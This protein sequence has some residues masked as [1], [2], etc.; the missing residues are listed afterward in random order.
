[1]GDVCFLA[2][3][4]DLPRPAIR[5]VGT[6]HF[7]NTTCFVQPLRQQAPHK[8]GTAGHAHLV[9]LCGQRVCPHAMADACRVGLLAVPAMVCVRAKVLKDVQLLLIHPLC[10]P[11][12][13]VGRDQSK[14]VNLAKISL[15]TQGLHKLRVM[16]HDDPQRRN[17]LHLSVIII[18]SCPPLAMRV[19][20]EL[21]DCSIQVSWRLERR[22]P[23]ETPPTLQSA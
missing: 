3:A 15:R 16:P 5:P 23:L 9:C 21:R 13:S 11:C 22:F 12:Y 14:E 1:M 8:I 20:S 4:H 10:T 17:G 18:R 19:L 2:A 6:G 7:G